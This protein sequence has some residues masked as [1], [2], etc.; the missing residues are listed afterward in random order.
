M[1]FLQIILDYLKD[2]HLGK[3]VTRK[4]R[5]EEKAQ[6]RGQ[7]RRYNYRHGIRK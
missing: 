4:P 2:T 6:F 5:I 7:R 3:G 1:N